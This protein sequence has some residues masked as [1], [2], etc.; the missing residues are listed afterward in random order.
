MNRLCILLDENGEI[1]RICADEE[2]EIFWV[3]PNVKHDRVYKYGSAD[4]GPQF[5]RELIGGFPIGHLHDG[6]L[7]IGNE[8]KY[9]PSKPH[10][11][12]L[13]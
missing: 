2:L 9:P 10:L 12:V 6:T 1:D 13:A 7:G 11:K 5:V 8:R 4:F 3:N